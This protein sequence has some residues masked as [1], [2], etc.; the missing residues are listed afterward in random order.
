MHVTA[1]P[2]IPGDDVATAAPE[3]HLTAHDAFTRA[4]P[5]LAEV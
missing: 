5:E 2:D 3:A 4:E 1:V